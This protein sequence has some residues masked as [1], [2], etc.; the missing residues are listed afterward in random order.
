MDFKL[1]AYVTMLNQIEAITRH[2]NE[3]IEAWF[4]KR[5]PL[6]GHIL[7]FHPSTLNH[8]N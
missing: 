7:Y 5:F 6:N 3:I 4:L 1:I 8:I 2:Q